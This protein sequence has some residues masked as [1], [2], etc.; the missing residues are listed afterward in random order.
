MN[1][2]LAVSL[3]I[4][5]YG[6]GATDQVAPKTEPAQEYLNSSWQR[7][8]PWTAILP[9]VSGNP[10]GLAVLIDERGYFVAHTSSIVSEPITAILSDGTKVRL[11]R[12]GFDS[13]T[14]LVLFGAQNWTAEGRA[15]ATIGSSSDMENAVTLATV[16][17]PKAGVISSRDRAGVMQNSQRYMRFQEIQMERENFPVGGALVL[18]K[19]GDLIG[20]LGATLS[21]LKSGI[22]VDQNRANMNLERQFGPQGLLVGYALGPKT[23]QRVFDGFRSD[24]HKVG[25]PTIG[26]QFRSNPTGE[27]VLIDDVAKQSPADK[28]GILFGDVIIKADNREVKTPVDFAT[29]LFDMNPGEDL[30]LEYKRGPLTLKTSVLVGSSNLTE[31]DLDINPIETIS[32]PTSVKKLRSI[33]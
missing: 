5:S 33:R 24:S 21:P 22:A 12:I 30:L 8:Q 7:A 3:A 2:V 27:G 1:Y 18:S 23:L 31:A 11:G 20:I 6:F 15:L 16:T 26:V 32:A 29:I 25:H 14:E 28:A 13:A 4:A 9:D 19:S 10:F 17:G